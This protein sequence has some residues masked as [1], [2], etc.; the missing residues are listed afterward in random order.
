MASVPICSGQTSNKL[1]LQPLVNLPSTC[2]T[3]WECLTPARGVPGGQSASTCLGIWS[4]KGCHTSTCWGICQFRDPR[5]STCLKLL[6]DPILQRLTCLDLPGDSISRRL[7]CL[8]LPGDLHPDLGMP[9]SRVATLL[10]RISFKKTHPLRKST[11]GNRRK[12]ISCGTTPCPSTVSGV[13]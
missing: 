6:S 9:G 13:Q 8:S 2:W 1:R 12:P 10:G 11:H 3:P 5:G 4:S 7:P